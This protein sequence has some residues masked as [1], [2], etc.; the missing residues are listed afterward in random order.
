M[1]RK[2]KCEIEFLQ[3]TKR[4]L[5]GS[6]PPFML[7]ASNSSSLVQPASPVSLITLS[8]LCLRSRGCCLYVFPFCTL[9]VVHLFFVSISSHA[10][11]IVIVII[12]LLKLFFLIVSRASCIWTSKCFYQIYKYAWVGLGSTFLLE[13]GEWVDARLG[14]SDP[15]NFYMSGCTQ[16]GLIFGCYK[17]VLTWITL[18]VLLFNLSLSSSPHF[19][20]NVGISGLLTKKH[21]LNHGDKSSFQKWSSCDGWTSYTIFSAWQVSSLCVLSSSQTYRF[22]H[23]DY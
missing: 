10:T 9:L 1:R 13:P 8:T 19:F 5:R 21:G 4:V 22:S 2:L 23:P 20:L 17:P 3:W 11:D 15:V 12:S 6:S 7:C 14:W 16:E 18:T